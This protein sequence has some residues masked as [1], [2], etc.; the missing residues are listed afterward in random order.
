MAMKLGSNSNL[1]KNNKNNVTYITNNE[2]KMNGRVS[3][4][5]TLYSHNT[6]RVC[7]NAAIGNL[8]R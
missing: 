1:P 4:T 2:E 7:E 8:K 3:H 6:D 5:L